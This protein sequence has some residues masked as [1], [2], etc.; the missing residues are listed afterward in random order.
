[1]TSC[2]TAWLSDR[3]GG[4]VG[5]RPSGP[6]RAGR[7]AYRRLN[8]L[9]TP[10][11]GP[12]SRWTKPCL[13]AV[14]D[15]RASTRRRSAVRRARRRRSIT[16]CSSP[17]SIRRWWIRA[18]IAHPNF[19]HFRKRGHEVAVASFAHSLARCRFE[20]R[21][22]LHAGHGRG[23]CHAS[24]SG[25][26]WHVADAQAA[27]LGARGQMP[28]AS[29][30]I[31]S[32]GFI[33]AKARRVA[34]NRQRSAWQRRG[35]RKAVDGVLVVARQRHPGAVLVAALAAG[36]GVGHEHQAADGQGVDPA[37]G[38]D[39][40]EVFDAGAAGEVEIAER[41]GAEEQHVLRAGQLAAAVGALED[42]RLVLAGQQ[43][44]GAA[45]GVDVAV[46][47]E[48]AGDVFGCFVP[49][50]SPVLPRT[51]ASRPPTSEGSLKRVD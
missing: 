28:L 16:G 29:R 45:L 21:S 50:R 5:T 4:P 20:R 3:V 42:E 6:T 30:A 31:R 23:D 48:R 34:H 32:W 46:V 40:A 10:F 24:G 14:A 44:P 11:R 36:G 37:A 8:S 15:E 43:V 13:V 18:V 22:A 26:P 51:T 1:M 33:H 19:T 47:D 17:A 27:R 12:T 38:A 2:L 35:N 49:E 25:R 7:G 41:G 39:A 9:A